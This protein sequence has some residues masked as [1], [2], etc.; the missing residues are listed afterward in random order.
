M[1][2][3]RRR[4]TD[5]PEKSPFEEGADKSRCR[6][7]IP[8]NPPSKGDLSRTR[9]HIEHATIAICPVSIPRQPQTTRSR[10]ATGANRSRCSVDGV[11]KGIPSGPA[12]WSPSQGNRSPENPPSK[13]GPTKHQEWLTP[14]SSSEAVVRDFREMGI[15]Q[16]AVVGC[17][18]PTCVLF[19]SPFEGGFRGMF[20][21]IDFCRWR[22]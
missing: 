10:H 4:P 7:N 2:A 6:G 18:M 3:P 21:S 16:T 22:L 20:P 15:G 1:N 5:F 14:V 13:T 17:I 19:R 11:L 12:C 9:A 8:L